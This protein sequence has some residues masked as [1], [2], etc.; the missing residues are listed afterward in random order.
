MKTILLGGFFALALLAPGTLMAGVIRGILRVPAGSVASA[1]AI[2]PYPGRASSMPGHRPKAL[3]GVMDAVIHVD[4]VPVA[5]E[6]LL[7]ATTRDRPKLAQANQAFVPRVLAIAVGTSVDF[8]NQDPIYHNVFSLS[9]TRRFDLGKYPRGGSRRV[10]F[11]KVGLVNVYC[12][13]HSDMEAF[14]LVLPHHGFTRPA[15]SGEFRL[16][17]LPAG[18]YMLRAWH[19][20]LGERTVNVEVPESGMVAVDLSY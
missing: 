6:S 16:P 14:V 8:P 19:P 7:A 5:T 2:N 17:E 3:G 1:A 9:P 10:V 13:I 12:D 15:A 11:P 4:R 20:D 18:R